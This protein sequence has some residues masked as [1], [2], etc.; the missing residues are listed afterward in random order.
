MNLFTRLITYPGR[1]MYRWAEDDL[2]EIQQL[3]NKLDREGVPAVA[4]SLEVGMAEQMIH[5]STIAQRLR[6]RGVR[7]VDYA[8]GNL[9]I[10]VGA[11]AAAALVTWLLLLWVGV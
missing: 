6:D 3:R 9:E 2:D 8:M 5:L 7:P 4:R 11:V 10:W 1:L